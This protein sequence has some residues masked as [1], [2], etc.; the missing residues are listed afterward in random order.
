[1]NTTSIELPDDLV[2]DIDELAAINDRD[3]TQQIRIMLYGQVIA[4]LKLHRDIAHQL[5]RPKDFSR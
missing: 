3:R 2:S 1:M 5:N 4:D